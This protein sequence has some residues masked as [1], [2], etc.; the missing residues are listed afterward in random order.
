MKCSLLLLLVSGFLF[1]CNYTVYK[2]TSASSKIISPCDSV[3]NPILHPIVQMPGKTPSNFAFKYIYGSRTIIDA[4]RGTF[5]KDMVAEPDTTIPFHFKPEQLD[6]IYSKMLEFD[7][8]NFP[9]EWSI[10]DFH[11]YGCW[12]N[13]ILLLRADS[14]ARSIQIIPRLPKY[15]IY[16]HKIDQI[17]KLILKY[18]YE[19]EEYK[20]LPAVR[21]GRL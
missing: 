19:S 13:H 18:V 5:T 15:N 20:R 21:S 14:V 1:S 4:F 12:E 8:F 2:Q 3:P 10:E 9:L 17:G 6:S 11:K 7:A 16:I